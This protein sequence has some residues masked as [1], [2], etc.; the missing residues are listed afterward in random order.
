M[1]LAGGA[2]DTTL[3]SGVRLLVRHEHGAVGERLLGY[4][5]RVSTTSMANES[6]ELTAGHLLWHETAAPRLHSG[7]TF[8]AEGPDICVN[9]RLPPR[10]ESFCPGE[11]EQ[12][13]AL[14]PFEPWRYELPGFT[15]T[16]PAG[17]T[18]ASWGRLVD[19]YETRLRVRVDAEGWAHEVVAEQW[20]DADGEY[21]DPEHA[22]PRRLHAWS[23]PAASK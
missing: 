2:F 18:L 11:H 19:V 14:T 8:F 7:A 12:R 21:R 1:V 15:C 17:A 4:A 23:A 5:L 9:L 10:E 20:C 3:V 16:R 13:W 6:W 22:A